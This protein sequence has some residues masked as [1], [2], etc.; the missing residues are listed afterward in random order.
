MDNLFDYFSLAIIIFFIYKGYRNGIIIEIATGLGLFGGLVFAKM[1][2]LQL[3]NN[4]SFIIENEITRDLSAFI[5]LF[6]SIIIISNIIGRD[7]K[8]I[9]NIILLG[10]IDKL[11]GA[12]FGFIKAM[13]IL[14]IIILL[15]SNMPIENMI[16]E[17]AQTSYFEQNINID[18]NT[19]YK[20]IRNLLPTEIN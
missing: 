13:L 12:G 4:L 18:T 16:I 14:K 8:K 5:S 10:Q 1:S 20:K 6:L 3:S 9:M 11:L 2:Y 7:I 17:D 15:I 19:F